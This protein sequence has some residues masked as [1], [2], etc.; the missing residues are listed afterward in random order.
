MAQIEVNPGE[1]LQSAEVLDAI[2]DDL[3]SCRH[4]LE[5]LRPGDVGASNISHALHRFADQWE[6]GMERMVE[7]VKWTAN[8]LRT[9]GQ[10]YTSV[11]DRIGSALGDGVE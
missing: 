8:A 4:H 1:L 6:Y 7:S 5:A 3:G 9:A 11:E 10:G 2:G